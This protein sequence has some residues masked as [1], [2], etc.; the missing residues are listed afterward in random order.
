M[1]TVAAIFDDQGTL[2]KAVSALEAAGLGDDIVQVS[3]GREADRA[4]EETQTPDEE[5]VGIPPIAAAGGL[6][7][8]SGPSPQASA[9]LLGTAFAANDALTNRFDALGDAAEPFRHALESG[10]KLIFL[11]TRKVA[12]AIAALEGAGAQQVYDPR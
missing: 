8:G 6:L 11:E 9:P 10:G 5:G 7:S 1:A 4:P 12:E 3:E 2:E